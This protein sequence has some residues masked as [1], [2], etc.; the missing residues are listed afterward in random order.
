MDLTWG[1]PSNP[2]EERVR[3]YLQ[4]LLLEIATVDRD[5]EPLRAYLDQVELMKDAVKFLEVSEEVV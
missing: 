4:N 1:F 3:F 2:G 5:E